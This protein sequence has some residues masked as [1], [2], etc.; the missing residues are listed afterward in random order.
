MTRSINPRRSAETEQHGLPSV[1]PTTF[2]P[3]E[4]KTMKDVYAST[5]PRYADN[6]YGL[7]TEITKKNGID[8]ISGSEAKSA[9]EIASIT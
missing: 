5:N 2:H 9:K 4:S 8:F 7:G 1:H 3:K 6:K